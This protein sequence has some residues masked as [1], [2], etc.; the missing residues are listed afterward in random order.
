MMAVA[1]GMSN[2]SAWLDALQE[3]FT[4]QGKPATEN[5]KSALEL[6]TQRLQLERERLDRQRAQDAD[7]A[8]NGTG[9]RG[10]KGAAST[11]P[12]YD[13]EDA[14]TIDGLLRDQNKKLTVPENDHDDLVMLSTNLSRYNDLL[15]EAALRAARGL[16][17][18]G[19]QPGENNTVTTQDG[20]QFRLNPQSLG[21]LNRLR[22]RTDAQAKGAPAGTKPA[23]PE[24]PIA[25]R[26]RQAVEATRAAA[27]RASADRTAATNERTRKAFDTRLGTDAPSTPDLTASRRLMKDKRYEEERGLSQTYDKQRRPFSSVLDRD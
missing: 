22:R 13:R 4:P 1:T 14:T 12:E 21:A 17:K 19:F 27:G 6:R 7:K 8:A 16:L 9:T 26:N 11:E 5:Q 25:A 23:T 3:G 2:G 20:Q 15:P 24:N 18:D 10:K